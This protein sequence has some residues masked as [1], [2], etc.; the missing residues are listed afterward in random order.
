MAL[1]IY[2][3]TRLPSITGTITVDGDAVDLTGKT[4]T[5]KMRAVGSATLKVSAAASIVTPPGSDGAVRYDWGATDLDTAGDYLAWWE[6]TTTADGKVQAHPEFL[7]D[8][9][10]H[11]QGATHLCEVADVR[12]YLQ[13]PGG[14]RAQD[15]I[16]ESFITRASAAIES[17]AQREFT[18]K[19]TLTRRF[20]VDGLLVD[21]APYDLRSATTVT[22]NPEA[23]GTVL[24]ANSGYMLE[25]AG[26]PSGTYRYLRLDAHQTF[27]STLTTN[28]DHA[29]LD[30]AGSWGMSAIPADVRQAAITTVGIWMRR[31][32]Q[33]FAT[34]FSIDEGR[35]ERPEA[36]PS[37][38]R[39]MLEPWRAG[40]GG[41]SGHA[42]RSRSRSRT[43]RSSAASKAQR[44][45]HGPGH[46]GAVALGRPAPGGAGARV[47][48]APVACSA[49]ASSPA[50]TTR[51]AWLTTAFRG[52][53]R[54]A[55]G[56]LE[57]GGVV[58]API[59]P[60]NRQAIAFGDVVVARVS[61]PR[62]Y[63]APRPSCAR[64]SPPAA[65]P[66]PTR[67]TASSPP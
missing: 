39:G 8:I 1:R 44:P 65:A 29:F 43:R 56:L 35:L 63:A 30:V 20:R 10:S 42:S 26:D 33:A 47:A 41:M 50:P 55:F 3:D 19:G 4:V 57:F 31:E 53:L 66:S 40:G 11:G 45:G 22:L 59:V 21:L 62:T 58:R 12:E 25:P 34:T 67:S 51:G 23:T 13:K 27:N 9:Q 52:R 5:F 28:F 24:T 7:I 38:V 14:D 36:L 18:D 60:V 49:P 48:L 2:E 61:G 64:R 16:V 15:T 17:Y 46:Q 6:V 54:R 37:A 32:V